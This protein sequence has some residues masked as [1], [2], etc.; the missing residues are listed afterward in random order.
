MLSSAVVSDSSYVLKLLTSLGSITF[1][2]KVLDNE[3][4][5]VKGAT[6]VLK[7]NDDKNYSKFN[8]YQT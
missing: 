8:S 3:L 6:S 4:D 2:N 1:E 5:G 7:T